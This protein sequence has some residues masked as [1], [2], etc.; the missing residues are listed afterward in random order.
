MFF[1]FLAC[2]CCQKK[3]NNNSP[4]RTRMMIFE[5]KKSTN[6]FQHST[7]VP[8]VKKIFIWKICEKLPF[9]IF[10]AFYNLN[11][12]FFYEIKLEDYFFTLI[13]NHKPWLRHWTHLSAGISYKK[14]PWSML[15]NDNR[16]WRKAL[17]SDIAK[18]KKKN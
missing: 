8:M 3:K 16:C 11:Q 15:G 2:S 4:T 12:I 13:F 6:S 1:F 5:T 17:M 14:T 18:K 7:F 9:N 10:L